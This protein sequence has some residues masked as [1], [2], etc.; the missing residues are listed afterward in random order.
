MILP[1]FYLSYSS[2]TQSPEEPSA[3]DQTP[4]EK[5]AM[6]GAV[7]LPGPTVNLSELQNVKNELRWVTKD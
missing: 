7:K 3:A 2:Q 1:C 4:E 5:K 6:P